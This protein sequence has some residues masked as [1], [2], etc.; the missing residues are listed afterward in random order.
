MEGAGVGAH[1]AL[2]AIHGRAQ[3]ELLVREHTL[4]RSLGLAADRLVLRFEIEQGNLHPPAPATG[5]NTSAA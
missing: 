3:H 2:E 1:L 5:W 4:D